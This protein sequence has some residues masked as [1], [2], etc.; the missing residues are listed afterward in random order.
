MALTE[1]L[2]VGDNEPCSALLRLWDFEVVALE[3][4]EEE[5]V[6]RMWP[7]VHALSPRLS[8]INGGR[9][10]PCQFSHLDLVYMLPSKPYSHYLW[11]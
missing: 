7:A 3:G 9:R 5:D 2:Y 11:I 4:G 8:Y 10:I 1:I 6:R